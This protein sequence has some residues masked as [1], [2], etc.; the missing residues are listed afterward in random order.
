MRTCAA[1]PGRSCQPCQPCRS[2]RGEASRP[3]SPRRCGSWRP[4][5]SLVRGSRGPEP[6]RARPPGTRRSESD[7]H[8]R[9]RSGPGRPSRGQG[10]RGGPAAEAHVHR[11]CAR[12]QERLQPF[13]ERAFV[14]QDPRPGRH[15]V[16]VAVLRLAVQ[17]VHAPGVLLPQ[18]LEVGLLPRGRAGPAAT[19]EG[20][21][22]TAVRTDGSTRTRSGCPVSRP[23]SARRPASGRSPAAPRTPRPVARTPAPPRRVPATPPRVPPAVRRPRAIPTST[24][25]HALRDSPFPQIPASAGDS[26]ARRGPCRNPP[27]AL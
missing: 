22:A 3:P 12:L 21:A 1:S 5:P 16:E 20:S 23:P 13:R 6:S 7:R 18:H 15:E 17:L 10:V 9:R 14:G 11:R 24:T 27:G 26:A 8:R 25:A 19:A 4:R 2:C